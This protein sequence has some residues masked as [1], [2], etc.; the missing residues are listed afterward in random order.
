MISEIYAAVCSVLG[1][2]RCRQI[3]SYP[4]FTAIRPPH[5]LDI[6]F[7]AGFSRDLSPDPS[8]AV[9][10][11]AKLIQ[12]NFVAPAGLR[13]VVRIQSHSVSIILFRSTEEEFGVDIVPAW[14]SG[15]KNNYGDDIFRVPELILRGH[16]KRQQKYERVKGGIG[17]ISFIL[18]DPVGYIHAAEEVNATNEDFRRSTKCGKKWKH[19]SREN[20]TQFKMK[21][22]HLEQILTSYFD[23]DAD[24]EIYAALVRFFEELPMW[25]SHSRIP[26]RADSTRM[27]DSYVDELTDAERTA[28]LSSRDEMLNRLRNFDGS[29]DVSALFES[30]KA[31]SVGSSGTGGAPAIIT[32][33]VSPKA[34]YGD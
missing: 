8:S 1:K 25:I 4:R 30:K 12:E 10:E 6:L 33:R 27:I 22:F 21:S 11:I 20:N 15:E 31:S 19:E 17:S 23:G 32:S 18:T 7:R 34:P 26:D 13:S 9:G 24:L 2:H 14:E 28:I 5:D 29:N 3:G 16:A